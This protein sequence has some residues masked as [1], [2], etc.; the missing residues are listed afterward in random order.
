[1]NIMKTQTVPHQATHP[2]EV[3][4]NELVSRDITQ[5]EFAQNID[6]QVTMLNEIIKG[7][8]TVTADIAVSLEKALDIQADF[9][10]SLQSQ[11]DLDVARIK[12]KNTQKL[13]YIEIWNVIKQYVPVA[14]FNK[15]GLLT[16]SLPNNIQKI[17]DIYGVQHLDDLIEN[18][19]RHKE[20]VLYKKSDKLKND[21]INIFAWS[22]LAMYK[23]KEIEVAGF[24]TKKEK[25][26]IEELKKVLVENKNVIESIQTI[27][28]NYGIR[29]FILEKFDKTP[30]DGYSFLSN[31]NPTIVLTLRK[32]TIDNLAF[33]LFHELGHLFK[34]FNYEA[35]CSFLNV[36]HGNYADDYLTMED[37]ANQYAKNKLI[38]DIIWATFKKQ[39]PTFQYN[40]TDTRMKELA[41]KVGIHPGILFGRYCFETNNYKIRTKIERNFN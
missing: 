17:W 12:E 35:P 16:N 14:A 39:N 41:A 19:A 15:L 22:K 9:W 18:F 6:M 37:E 21:Q 36:E 28:T 4:K 10:L 2:G 26:I 20:L 1:M 8:R 23:A 40:T 25:A 11:F 5:K 24:S 38:D 7:K 33:T 30:I 34:H 29:F 32:K 3:L 13:V 31:N 27:L